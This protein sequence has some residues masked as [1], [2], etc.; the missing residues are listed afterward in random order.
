L[1]GKTILLLLCIT[2][3]L[4]TSTTMLIKDTYAQT[5]IMAVEPQTIVDPTLT[6]SKTFKIN[7]T[8]KDVDGLYGWEFKL[9]Y[10]NAILNLTSTKFGPFLETG[11]TTFTIDKSNQNYNAT[12]GLVW[13]GDSLLGAPAGVNGSGTIAS[14]TF[15][16]NKMGSTKLDLTDTKM[17][18][19]TGEVITHEAQDGY[20]SNVVSNAKIS[21]SPEKIINASLE[22]SYNFSINILITDAVNVNGWELKL[23]YDHDILNVSNVEF[24]SFLQSLGSTNQQITQ[25]TD[26]YNATHGVVWLSETLTSPTGAF[27]SGILATITFHV[28]GVGETNLTLADTKLAD[29]TGQ[30]LTHTCSNGYFNNMLMAKIFIDPQEIF[31]PTLTPGAIVNVTVKIAEVADL[32]SFKFN[33]TYEKGI[34]NCLGV[35]ITPYQNEFNFDSKVSWDDNTGEI[36]VEINYHSPAEPITSFTPFEVAKIFFQVSGMGVSPLHF[37]DTSMADSQ[38]NNIIHTTQDGLIYIVIRDVAVIDLTVDKTE[39]YPGELVNVTVKVENKGN[40][41]ESFTVMLTYNNHFIANITIQ[42]LPPQAEQSASYIWN[43][44]GFSPSYNESITAYAAPVPYERNINDNTFTD[45][46]IKITL[47]GDVNGDGIVD[48]YDIT[49]AAISFASNRGDLEYN[50]RADINH[51]GTIDVFDL[52]LIGLHFGE[53]Y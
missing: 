1:K 43:T 24:G 18:T 29:P 48:I 30:P 4:I 37:H 50:E 7:I 19:K 51:D 41:T 6:P 49:L 44:T 32:Y 22:P 15:Q 12:H 27:G 23:Y 5:T 47:I 38:G 53:H 21:I 25:L 45:G 26:N 14:I 13:L 9:Y 52:I 40:L 46:I 8:V 28:E 10:L 34:L 42:D 35:L 39:V 2:F 3:P 36:S 31:D 17:G 11:G 20:F 16:V 33:L